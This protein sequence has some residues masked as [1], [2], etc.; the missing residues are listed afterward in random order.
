MVEFKTHYCSG[1]AQSRIAFVFSWPGKKEELGGKPTAGAT[2]ENLNE[3]LNILSRAKP[4]LFQSTNC[5]DYRITNSVSEVLYKEK[6]GRTEPNGGEVLASENLSRLANDLEN[7]DMVFYCGNKAE[8]AV[9]SLSTELPSF[10]LPHLGNQ[11]RN[12][13]YPT[14]TLGTFEGENT[15]KNRRLRRIELVA[16]DVLKQ[17]VGDLC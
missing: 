2:G 3:L 1:L 12:T 14:E 13:K 7:I 5:Y 9:S 10:S 11:S 16:D 17:L 6:N 4:D 15:S 8:L